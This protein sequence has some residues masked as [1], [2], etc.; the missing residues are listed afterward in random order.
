MRVAH[1]N[2]RALIYQV[3]AM[4]SLLE[5]HQSTD[6]EEEDGIAPT[7]SGLLGSL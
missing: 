2:G 5:N 1:K 3:R 4:R 6:V 7:D